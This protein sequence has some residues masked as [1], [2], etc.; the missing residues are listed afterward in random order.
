[1][2]CSIDNQTTSNSS[3]FQGVS[4]SITVDP[5]S[6]PKASLSINISNASS[7]M[8]NGEYWVYNNNGIVN[9]T[10]KNVSNCKIYNISN[11]TMVE[12]VDNTS[13]NNHENVGQF[14]IPTTQ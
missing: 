8:K 6:I 4:K 5:Q 14:V 1:M 7:N 11:N 3:Y 12:K 2:Y 10:A 13:D 9:W